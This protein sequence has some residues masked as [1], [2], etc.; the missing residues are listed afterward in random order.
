ML[1]D[2]LEELRM[3]AQK[4]RVQWRGTPGIHVKAELVL[5]LLEAYERLLEQESDE[6]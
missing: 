3:A 2:E 1:R 4:V 5:E 6:W